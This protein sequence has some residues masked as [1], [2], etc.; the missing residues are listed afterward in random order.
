LD[1]CRVLSGSFFFSKTGR[2]LAVIA[3]SGKEALSLLDISKQAAS[4][5]VR[6]GPSVAIG[7]ATRTETQEGG[8]QD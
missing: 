6:R 7:L 5:D 1:V 4:K 2:T 8:S 3:E